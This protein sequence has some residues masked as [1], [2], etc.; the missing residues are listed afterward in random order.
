MDGCAV[1]VIIDLFG[2]STSPFS[3]HC[4]LYSEPRNYNRGCRS[5]LD[6]LCARNLS[7]SVIADRGLNHFN[8]GSIPNRD[9]RLP[10]E[11]NIAETYTTLDSI[12]SFS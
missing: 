10:M 12:L 4:A 2:A 1:G 9:K 7:R 6:Q 8:C 3:S 5:I 11:T